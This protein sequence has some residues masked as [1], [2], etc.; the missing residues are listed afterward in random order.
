[1][2]RYFII[3]FYVVGQASTIRAA[4]MECF[5][6]NFKHTIVPEGYLDKVI[7]TLNNIQDAEYAKNKRLKKV[8]IHLNPP[9]EFNT[10][11]RTIQVGEGQIQMQEIVREYFD[12][13]MWSHGTAE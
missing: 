13:V 1:M 4:L 7:H 2:K 3:D 9:S 6:A 8:D 5:K 11:F 12:R 10:G